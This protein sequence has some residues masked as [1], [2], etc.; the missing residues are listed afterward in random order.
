MLN[1]EIPRLPRS[2]YVQSVETV[3]QSGPWNSLWLN[4]YKVTTV[5][6]INKH[7][8]VCMHDSVRT[9]YPITTKHDSYTPSHAYYLIR[10]W[11]NSVGNVF[12]YDLF[13]KFRVC[14]FSL[15]DT[16]EEWLV[17]SMWDNKKMHQ[18]DFGSTMR[19][20]PLTSPMTLTLALSR[21]HFVVALGNCYLIDVNW[22]MKTHQVDTEP[23]AW[24]WFST[25]PAWTLRIQGQSLK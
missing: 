14:L 23:V 13:S 6:L 19:P 20:W 7:L 25:T 2:V 22:E 21:P 18:L 16:S 9:T 8:I 5:A 3:N 17:R 24:P 10:L 1:T 11:R 4:S 12:A 15:L